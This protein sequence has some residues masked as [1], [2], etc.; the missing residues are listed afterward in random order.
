MKN[1][2]TQVFVALGV[3]LVILL[4]IAAYLFI[5]D[6]WH[7]KPLLFGSPATMQVPSSTSNKAA[8]P[9]NTTGTATTTTTTAAPAAAGGFTLSSAQVQALVSLGINPSSVPSTISAT[10]EACFVSVLGSARVDQ[11]KAGAVPNA[12][13]F[14]KAKA[15]L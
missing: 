13:E 6:P 15:C 14:L 4:V 1:F 10:Q 11:I 2:L 8:A 3:I 9:A 7:L 5:T 12:I